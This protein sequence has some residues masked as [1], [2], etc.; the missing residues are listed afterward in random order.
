LRR[1]DIVLVRVI[2]SAMAKFG[3]V[4]ISGILKLIAIYNNI[5]RV[6]PEVKKPKTQ[7]INL[8]KQR[9]FNS[10]FLY[11][12]AVMVQQKMESGRYR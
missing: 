2:F 1:G 10:L 11:P 4:D 8:I 7:L 9:I 5:S 12:I 3:R 6:S